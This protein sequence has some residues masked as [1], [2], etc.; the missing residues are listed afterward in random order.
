[1]MKQTKK[2]TKTKVPLLILA[3]FVIFVSGAFF[4]YQNALKPVQ[5]TSEE[6]V[7]IV[8]SGD[9]A[10]HIAEYLAENGVIKNA[11]AA[12]IYVKQ[13]NLNN[14]KVGTYHLDKSWDVKKIFMLLNDVT[15]ADRT[16]VKVTIPEGLWAKEIAAKIAEVTNVTADELLALWNNED[17]L[18]SIMPDYPFLTEDIFNDQLK[19]KLE[20]YL[21]PETYYFYAN[22]TAASITKKMLD[23]TELIYE[24]YKDAFDA[25]DYSIHELFTLASITQFEAG[26]IDDDK[27]VSGIWFNRLNA[28]MPLQSSVTVCYALYDYDHWSACEVNADLDSPYNT[29]KYAGIPIGP[30]D[31]PGENAIISVLYPTKTDYYYFIADVYGDGTIHYAKTY[32][33]HLA[34]IKKYL[35]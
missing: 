23:Q 27:L 33:E 21:F 3:G 2:K 11:N 34:N 20:G 10:K 22:T 31:N 28:K 13:A 29:Y 17:Y 8:E 6:F 30:I 16:D 5:A 7:L 32:S 25:S 4:W 24:K 18:R 12:Y 26:D 9:T 35:N 1:M 14:I 19:V 15:G